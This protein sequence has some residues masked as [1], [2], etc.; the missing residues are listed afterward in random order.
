MV[1]EGRKINEL[2]YIDAD[3]NLVEVISN[4]TDQWFDLSE[5]FEDWYEDV[6]DTYKKV[7]TYEKTMTSFTTTLANVHQENPLPTKLDPSTLSRSKVAEIEV[8]VT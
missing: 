1:D 3:N 2:D 5:A 7:Q 8:L 6:T 4:F